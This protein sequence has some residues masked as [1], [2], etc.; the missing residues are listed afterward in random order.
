MTVVPV[1][2][3]EK[4]KKILAI[5]EDSRGVPWMTTSGAYASND[6]EVIYGT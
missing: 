2:D 1:I 3:E 5:S 6:D 4:Y